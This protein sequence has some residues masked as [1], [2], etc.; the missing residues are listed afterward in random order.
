MQKVEKK[1]EYI[2]RY[3]CIK[4][5]NILKRYTPSQKDEFMLY[6]TQQVALTYYVRALRCIKIFAIT[7]KKFLRD[8]VGLG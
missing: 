1:K 5:Y 4:E 8:G 6:L 2:K 3:I 7:N